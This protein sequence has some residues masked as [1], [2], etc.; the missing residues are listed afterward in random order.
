M[1][2]LNESALE[3]LLANAKTTS[4]ANSAGS[5]ILP[6]AKAGEYKIEHIRVISIAYSIEY[7]TWT[8]EI[9]VKKDDEAAQ[10][11]KR[12]KLTV[13]ESQ[14][15]MWQKI[16]MDMVIEDEAVFNFSSFISETETEIPADE[17]TG[18]DDNDVPKNPWINAH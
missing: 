10:A 7:K 4:K 15:P 17:A 8:V 9:S 3:H 14:V 13:D 2:K 6:T 11:M 16:Q 5:K 12:F 1:N 18:S